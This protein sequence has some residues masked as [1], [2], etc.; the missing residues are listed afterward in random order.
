LVKTLPLFSLVVQHQQATTEPQRSMLLGQLR[1]HLHP[2]PPFHFT[3][4]FLRLLSSG[5]AAAQARL[6]SSVST[7]AQAPPLN[8]HFASVAVDYLTR[9]CGLPSDVAIRVS[10][11]IQHLKSPDNPDAVLR[12]L[13]QAGICES[14]IRAAVSREPRIL[15][16]SVEKNLRPDLAKLQEIGLSIKDIS[17][18]IARTPI[19]FAF[20][21]V[22]KID[23]LV[24]DLGSAELVSTFIKRNPVFLSSNLERVVVP[25]LSF[26]RDKFNLSLNQIVLLMNQAPRLI[27]SNPDTLK[28]KV[29]RAEDIGAAYGQRTIVYALIIAS[30]LSQHVI[31]ARVNYLTSLRISREDVNYMIAQTPLLLR[32]PEEQIGR[33]MQFLIN[34][35]GCDNSYILRNPS[36]LMYSLEKRLIP[37]NLI[38]KIL[39]SKEHPAADNK[40]ASFVLPSEKDFVKKFVLPYEH[41]IPGLRQACMDACGGKIV[42]QEWS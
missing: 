3:I 18:I 35:V 22:P 19:V 33:K 16:S 10:K 8:P 7:A 25:N 41:A 5:G 20:N 24:G 29:K 40:F 15:C 37:R 6:R 14:T 1:H 34:E 23:F 42:A 2:S 30:N 26:L 38:R 28:I 9:S 13:R 32:V 4:P 17:G 31:D 39:K 36:L 12:F 21:I 27:T 11:K